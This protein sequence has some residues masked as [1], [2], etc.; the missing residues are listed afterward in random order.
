M[1]RFRYFLPLTSLLLI[2][3]VLAGA[4]NATSLWRQAP[5][6]VE[7]AL[8]R[9]LQEFFE[10]QME[11][12]WGA[13]MKYIHEDS[14]DA[15]IG[16][17]KDSCKSLEA[18]NIT[19]NDGF[20]EATVGVLC[21]RGMA[22]PVGGGLAKMPFTMYW[23][24]VN[25]DWKWFTPKGERRPEEEVVMTPFGP[26]PAVTPDNLRDRSANAPDPSH[27]F[28]TGPSVEDLQGPIKVKPEKLILRADTATSG[29]A[30]IQNTFPGMVRISLQ[31]VALDGLSAT[32]NK[33]ELQSGET[34]EVTVRFEPPGLAMPP[35]THA[36]WVETNPMRSATPVIVE[37]RMEEEIDPA[38]GQ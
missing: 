27:K 34:A 3:S 2:A 5:P 12:K 22:T 14:L 26:V 4:Q 33:K 13:S 15:Y 9:T 17:E 25:E 30:I 1:L 29:V 31:R 24:R 7:K 28:S 21:E 19:Y 37:F 18:F 38:N 11:K 10:L 36:V 32:V 16:S 23:K 20:T 6:E 35:R 8:Q